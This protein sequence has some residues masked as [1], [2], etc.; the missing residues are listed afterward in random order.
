M[1]NKTG[2]MNTLAALVEDK[3]LPVVQFN[4]N[5]V[6]S[7]LVYKL[8]GAEEMFLENTDVESTL[9]AWFNDINEDK[10]GVFETIG[11]I[12]NS[13]AEGL[14]QAS[15]T[16]KEIRKNVAEL[17][18]TIKN[19]SEKRMA[20]DA[21]LVAA[22]KRLQMVPN[23]DTYGFDMLKYVGDRLHVVEHVEKV[24]SVP[25]DLTDKARFEVATARYLNKALGGLK[26]SKLTLKPE[27]RD[28]LVQETNTHSE[29]KSADT[30]YALIGMLVDGERLMRAFREAQ[31]MLTPETDV[32]DAFFYFTTFIHENCRALKT[33]EA[34]LVELGIEGDKLSENISII[35]MIAEIGA[36]YIYHQRGTT[37]KDTVLFR[38]GTRNPD[39]NVAMT[40]NEFGDNDI[41]NHLQYVVA[42]A[43][44]SKFG[45]TFS[46]LQE[47]KKSVDEQ[48][49]KDDLAAK[50]YI[51]ATTD[52]ILLDVLMSRMTEFLQASVGDIEDSTIQ[53]IAN[54]ITR[55]SVPVEDLIYEMIV[56][57]TYPGTL[58]EAMYN[59]L[60]SS[61]AEL[62]EKSKEVGDEQVNRTILQVY[63]KLMTNF[64]LTKYTESVPK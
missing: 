3:T 10:S 61:L 36:Y 30:L 43:P 17:A 63:T 26:P 55:Y 52:H 27:D 42:G 59:E 23:Y 50:T 20:A 48:A 7:E 33:I 38:N 56:T 12:A 5:T 39:L 14:L 9:A 15:G 40:N 34:K 13:F 4:N 51:A 11:T 2:I 28:K 19:D 62:V 1:F 32:N 57:T 6:L 54:R 18:T 29:T 35:N 8:T 45:V 53:P 24:A 41:H 47:K 60:G 16:L 46:R 22:N 64:L 37:F 21:K 25:S 31:S 44:L 58:V 49:A